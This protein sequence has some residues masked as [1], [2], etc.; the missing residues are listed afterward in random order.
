MVLR[1]ALREIRRSPGTALPIVLTIALAIGFVSTAVAVVDGV[2][3]RPL[4]YADAG[5][6]ITLD[7]AVLRSEIADWRA[8]LRSVED[9]VGAASADHAVR[10][11]GRARILRVAFVSR[12][13]FAT[14]RPQV[15]AGRLPAAGERGSVVVSERIL[16]EGGIR[17]GAALGMTLTVLGGSFT[18]ASVVPADAGIPE[19]TTDIWLPAEA[20][21]AVAL[22]RADDRRFGLIGRLRADATIAQVAT[23]A[24]RLRRALWTGNDAERGTLAVGVVPTEQ[25]ARGTRGTALLAFLVGGIVILLV[26]TANVA[27][28]LISRSV[29]RER[30]L[31][32]A[33]ALGASWQ[34]LARS[35]F[36]EAV[37]LAALGGALG[38]ALSA[39]GVRVLQAMASGALTRIELARVDVSTMVFCGIASAG[40]AVL[41]TIAPAWLTLRRGVAPL[42][43]SGAGTPRR[44]GRLQAALAS[45]QLALAIVLVVTAA[46]LTRTIVN[47]LDVPTG[48]RVDGALTA[49][50][51]LGERTLLSTGESRALADR[52]LGEVERLPGVRHAAFASS[53]PPAASIVQM[54]IRVVEG[55]RDETQM[56]ALVTATPSWADA[57]G[58]RVVDGRFLG[59]SDASGEHPGVV[60]SRATARHLF[61]NRRAVGLSLPYPIPGTAG[62][63]A[64]VVGVI[65]DVRYAG[66]AGP[67]QG[68]V[69]VP[70]E[71][72]PFGMV[73]L[74]VRT[75]G[76]PRSLAAPMATLARRLDP[77]RPIEDV[78]PLS[79][80]VADSVAGPRTYAVVASALGI[81]SLAVAL[82]GLLATLSRVVTVRRHELAVRMAVGATAPQ[83]LTLV[84]REAALVIAA[85]VMAGIPLAWAAGNGIAS[86]LYGVSAT[87]LDTYAAV[88]VATSAAAL[89]SSMW[90][91][92]R[93][94]STSPVELLRIDGTR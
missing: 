35:L 3:L 49:R 82:V 75:D 66:L 61:G 91:A 48:V 11:L 70:W 30:E 57:A 45:A 12:G 56:M 65:D 26:A 13:F 89:L 64:T 40:V 22:M 27:S 71:A 86:T 8:R 16:R 50:V 78:E 74:I 81:T 77:D 38:L 76:D 94:L 58:V 10:G 85:G 2:L 15:L 18:V 60:V 41:C 47:I 53:L 9:I 51:M 24:T 44:G 17:P 72:L 67:L 62:R 5:R 79:D 42:V 33:L 93:A 43:R 19:A 14:V 25:Q 29:A 88:G 37:I 1:L 63:R 90:P 59:A 23:E 7:H 83:L 6:L 52:W 31:A 84:L 73:R 46:L 4:P 68:A 39:A 80:V 36:A 54:A 69:Y 87:G 55:G 32:V 20:A 21:D 34:R 28:L 92:C